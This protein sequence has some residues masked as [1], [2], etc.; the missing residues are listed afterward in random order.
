MARPKEFDRDQ[1]LACAMDVFW[2]KG[3]ENASLDD[4]TQA[5]GVGR[6][7][8]YDTFGDKRALYLAALQH[9]REAGEGEMLAALE[10][11]QPLR[12]AVRACLDYVIRAVSTEGKRRGCLLVDAAVE[13]S[14][15]D[16][17]VRRCVEGACGARTKA[18]ER[19]FIRAQKEGEL[20]A[21]HDPRALAHFF[22]STVQ[23]L[24]VVAK[25]SGDRQALEQIARV[26]LSVLG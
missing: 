2:T 3:F 5:T 14:E 4:L 16:E 17:D 12:L 10:G 26:A 8:L 7:S 20:G 11:P 13:R 15:H 23:G 1:A 6:Q 24:I 21:H 25:S 9:Y 19:R 18:L 22:Y